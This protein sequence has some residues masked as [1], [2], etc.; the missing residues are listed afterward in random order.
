M[1]KNNLKS[2]ANLA[3]QR[4][5]Q[6]NYTKDLAKSVISKTR[7][8]SYFYRNAM[9]IRRKGLTVEFV[10]ITENDDNFEKKVFNILNSSSDNMRPIG[11]L[12]DRVYYSGL[13]DYEKQYYLLALCEKY[14]KAKEKYFS[15]EQK[16]S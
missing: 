5:K 7:A 12:I 16:I 9:A 14:N 2:L 8:S 4:L 1:E 10:T 13:N 15:L 6:G 11:Q 3:K